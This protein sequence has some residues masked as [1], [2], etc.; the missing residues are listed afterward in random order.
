MAGPPIPAAQKTSILPLGADVG[1]A[2][3]NNHPAHHKEHRAAPETP[4]THS[5]TL[6]LPLRPGLQLPL[7]LQLGV[8]ETLI[9]SAPKPLKQLAGQGNVRKGNSLPSPHH[10]HHHRHG[11][12]SKKWE[13]DKLEPGPLGKGPPERCAARIIT[14]DFVFWGTGSTFPVQAVWGVRVACCFPVK[15]FNTSVVTLR[16][17]QA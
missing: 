17:D 12:S 10:H 3:S 6:F 5:R 8:G 15:H 2:M 14:K 11:H 1:S 7:H 16:C 9:P 4:P 13:S